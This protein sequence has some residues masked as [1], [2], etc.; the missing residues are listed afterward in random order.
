VKGDE[1]NE[2]LRGVDTFKIV[3]GY[4]EPEMK[5]NFS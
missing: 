3:K 5:V 1:G 2:N 4:E